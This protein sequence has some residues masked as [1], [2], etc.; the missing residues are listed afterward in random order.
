[1]KLQFYK[2]G[3]PTKTIKRIVILLCVFVVSIVFFE[4]ITNVSEVMEVSHQSSP[5]LP[6]VNVNFLDDASTE[7]HGYVNQMDPAY[8]RDAIIPLDSNRNISLS[9]D[10]KNHHVDKLFYEIRSLDTQRNI[11]KNELKFKK[12][13]DI[14]SASF[15]AENLIEKNEEYLLI[16]TLTDGDDSIYYYTRIMEPDGCNE[17]KILDFAQYFH[18]TALSDDATDLA[19]YIEPKP[20]SNTTDLY[21][22]DINSNLDQISYATFK[23]TQVGDTQV[24]LTDISTNY[25]SLTLGYTLTINDGGKPEYYTCSEDYRVRYTAERIYLLD[26]NRTMNQLLDENSFV[27]KNNLV[28]IGITDSNVPYLSNE[29]GTIVSFV[30]NGCL[31]QYNQT[32]RQL[33][34][35]F[36]IQ[37]A[38]DSSFKH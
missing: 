35:I 16:I 11:S 3:I 28:N 20:S 22:V 5:T 25:V 37:S 38:Q 18:K 21:H 4:I 27:V 1:M 6:I 14:L 9:V 24:A 31:F 23:G 19:T 34:E 10:C 7:L 2:K 15:Q 17:D 32:N 36:H 29:T 12:K 26:Y 30:Q 33:K 8:M 13:D